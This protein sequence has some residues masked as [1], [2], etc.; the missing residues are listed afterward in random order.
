MKRLVILLLF[1][2][3]SNYAPAQ[4][5]AIDSLNKLISKA[6]S[7]TQR[8]NLTISKMGVLGNINLDSAIALAIKTI[9]EAKKINYKKGEVALRIKLAGDY[10]FTGKYPAAKENLDIAKQILLEIKDS[11][12]FGR[13]YD[14]YGFMSSMQ[15]KFDSGHLFFEKAIAAATLSNDKAMLNTIYQN[16]AIAYQQQSNY[17]QA[18][19]NYQKALKISEQLNDE[20]TEAYICLNIG[21]TYNTL[22]D[23]K[24][25]TIIF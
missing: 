23:T 18:L 10:C 14:V 12:E 19:A 21:I 22:D 13:L 20:E 2:H 3:F 8:I 25:R 15:N 6:S 17:P 7:D 11:A 1:F 24:S 4:T 16:D 9:E 5:A